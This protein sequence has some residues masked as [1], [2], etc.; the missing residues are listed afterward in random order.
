MKPGFFCA[1]WTYFIIIVIIIFFLQVHNQ[2]LFVCRHCFHRSSIFR[3]SYSAFINNTILTMSFIV[4]F[5]LFL[6]RE[7]SLRDYIIRFS[8]CFRITS[9]LNSRD[10]YSPLS[11][12]KKHN[13]HYFIN[14]HC[15][16]H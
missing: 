7:I 4:K 2:D 13:I 16:L 12:K 15:V 3:V 6:I 10:I 8:A 1:I 14:K 5:S 9:N 11:L